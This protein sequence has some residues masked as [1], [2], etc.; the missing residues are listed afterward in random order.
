MGKASIIYVIGLSMMLGYAL[1]T[2]SSN[3]TSS[4]DNYTMYYGRSMAHNL[5]IT[6]ANIG[7]QLLMRDPG[8]TGDLINR[9]YAGGTFS[10]Y[11]TK[12]GGDSAFVKCYSRIDVS[13]ETIRDTVLACLK[14]TSLS[15]YG[16]FTEEERNGYHGSIFFG[17]NDWKITG[18][19]VFGPAHTNWKFNLAGA[20]YF[21]DKV[22]A[23]NAPNIMMMDHLKDP[24]FRSGYQW[25]VTVARPT[26]NMANLSTLASTAGALFNGQ[27]VALTF[28]NDRVAVRIPP[29]TGV[30]RNDTV[31]ISSLTSNGVIAVMN[32]DLRV[33]GTYSGKITIVANNDGAATNKGN[34]WLDGNGIMAHDNP[35]VNPSSQDMMG[36]VANNN[37]TITQD[38]TRNTSTVFNIIAS[39]YCQN[40]ELT[41]EN[42]WS[43]PLSGRVNLFGGI[44]QY[45]AGS[46]GTFNPGH[47][48]LSGFNYT[49]RYDPRL[50]QGMRPLG[51]PMSS[52]YEL[53]SWW[54]N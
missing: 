54:E 48:M 32:G 29:S 50:S 22:T 31:P 43:I 38:L 39:V 7:T 28:L 4:M 33:K 17:Q 20:P 44:Q 9:T 41:T 21:H 6:G 12:P 15:K 16:W 49:I 27:D 25:G 18:D 24:V 8:Y 26:A 47:G 11:I 10:M 53:V 19:S 37:V 2:I 51:Y 3:S 42:F 35:Q 34:V 23:T 14:F 45:H 40:G 5:A 46:M 36:I 13:G 52:K 1:L 30:T